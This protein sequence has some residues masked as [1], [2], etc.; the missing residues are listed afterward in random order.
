MHTQERESEVRFQI[1]NI[2]KAIHKWKISVQKIL[3]DGYIL[4]IH[5]RMLTHI[6]NLIIK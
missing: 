2:S 4:I 1:R 5:A 3:S 6:Q